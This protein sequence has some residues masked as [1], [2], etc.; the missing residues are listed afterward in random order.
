MTIVVANMQTS[1]KERGSIRNIFAIGEWLGIA[2]NDRYGSRVHLTLATPIRRE[3]IPAALAK[4]V[5]EFKPTRI[6]T[7]RNFPDGKFRGLGE[8]RGK[9]NR[10]V[11]VTHFPLAG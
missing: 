8:L 2:P 4:H 9:W 3:D 5:P 6:L 11:R 7:P 1:Q 10:T